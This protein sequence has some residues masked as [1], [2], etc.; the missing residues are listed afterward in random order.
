VFIAS[1]SVTKPYLVHQHPEAV[2]KYGASSVVYPPL[3]W[4]NFGVVFE[5]DWAQVKQIGSSLRDKRQILQKLLKICKYILNN[6]S[7]RIWSH[8][9]AVRT[10]GF[11]PGNRGSI[12]LGITTKKAQHCVWAFFV[13]GFLNGLTQR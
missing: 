1:S 9:L 4:Y 13:V 10:P 5:P 6:I 12:P 11:H 8:R 7:L 2:Y 3:L